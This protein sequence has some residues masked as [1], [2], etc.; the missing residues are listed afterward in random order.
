MKIRQFNRLS[1]ANKIK[2]IR[3][4]KGSNHLTTTDKRLVEK[5]VV[6][7]SAAVRET[8]NALNAGRTRYSMRT[9]VEYLRHNTVVEDTGV[10]FKINDHLCPSMSRVCMALF[11]DMPPKFFELRGRNKIYISF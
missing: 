11:D 9:I 10:T 2:A 6:V 8:V 1:K 5:E 7:F 4:L 3:A